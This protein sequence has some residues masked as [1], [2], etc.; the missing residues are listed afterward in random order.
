MG[1]SLRDQTSE[2]PYEIIVLYIVVYGQTYGCKLV[3]TPIR[4]MP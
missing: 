2:T 4:E 3:L 1:L